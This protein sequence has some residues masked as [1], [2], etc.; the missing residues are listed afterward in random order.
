[1][2]IEN[3][4]L[5]ITPRE[6]EIYNNLCNGEGQADIAKTLNVSQPY[7][8]QITKQLESI[9]AIKHINIDRKV[10]YKKKY[11]KPDHTI[12]VEIYKPILRNRCKECHK[13]I[14]KGKK[15]CNQ[16]CMGLGT[17]G[18]KNPNWNGGT[19]YQP[20]CWKFNEPLKER[21][22]IF[23]KRKCFLCGCGED[24][25]ISLSVHHV[26]YN[27]A[28][29]CDKGG[30]PHFVPLCERCHNMTSSSSSKDQW[31][32]ILSYLLFDRTDGECYIT[33][34]EYREILNNEKNN[35]V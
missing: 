9:G 34:K 10:S 27:K 11:Q 8:N 25:R 7:I 14:P 35:I 22:R 28:A 16:V 4:I 20:Y 6:A 3:N 1:M 13:E 24:P 17:R 32:R 31:D 2:K 23:F 29:C 19:K 18:P 5:I 12:E 33:K 15:F 21:V 26:H 30:Q